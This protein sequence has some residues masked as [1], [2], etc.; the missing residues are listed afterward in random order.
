MKPLAPLKPVPSFAAVR[1]VY[2][3][4]PGSGGFVPQ[5]LVNH[6]AGAARPGDTR[7]T[8]IWEL[9]ASLHCSIIGTCL[10]TGELRGLLRKFTRP[11]TETP[12]DHDLHTLAVS[13]A[14]KHD[15]VAKQIQKALDRRHAGTILRFAKA[16]ALDDL[17]RLWDEAVQSGDIPGA[18]WAAMTHPLATDA[19]VRRV[20]GDVHMLSHLVGAANRAD[21]RRLRQLEEEKAILEAKLA[22]QQTHL[23][24]GI[25][26]RDARIRELTDMLSARIEKDGASGSAPA[27]PTSERATL[28]ALVADVRKQ[29]DIE[30]RRRQRA[31]T[32][33]AEMMETRTK[34]DAAR[35]TM[36]QDLQVLRA[37]LGAA[38]TALS[39][40]SDG[41]SED[42]PSLLLR[43]MTIL[44]VGGRTH[45]I[46]RLK[47]IVEQASGQFV[48]HDGGVEERTDLLPGL[49]SRA[50]AACFPVDCISHPAALLLKRLCRQAGKPYVPLRSSGVASLLYGLR[51]LEVLPELQQA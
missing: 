29:L 26:V 39:G 18:Y 31:E 2:P 25:V 28:N 16:T 24:D 8:K 27:N 20:F 22:R 7:R 47:S 3:G 13:A 43:G 19:V 9:A 32:R 5:S 51:S 17:Y 6:P 45:L 42:T 21:I 14:G 37:E 35:L 15:L 10:T 30:I 34:D 41:S 44:Y 12:T 1:P 40:L 11:S 4:L 49:V 33:V 48:H 38:E 50:D 36:E 46:A 23:H